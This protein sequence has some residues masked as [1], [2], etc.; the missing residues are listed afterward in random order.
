MEEA[1]LCQC[2]CGEPVKRNFRGTCWNKYIHRHHKTGKFEKGG[3][4][5]NKGVKGAM[6]GSTTSFKK[7]RIPW[8]KGTKGAMK[9][10]NKGTTL[11][12]VGRAKLSEAHKGNIPWNKDKTGIYS[13]EALAK[14]SKAKIGHIPWNKGKTGIY[15]EEH[16]RRMSETRRK[17]K[18]RVFKGS[19]DITSYTWGWNVAFREKIRERDGRICQICGMDEGEN[20][21]RLSVH[22][23]NG[24]RCDSSPCNLI[25]LCNVCHAG[26]IKKPKLWH[27]YLEGQQFLDVYCA[28]H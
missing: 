21:R 27:A 8:N 1:P 4:P 14:M 19:G 7:G 17:G 26:T 3:T 25:S 15:S 6:K 11:D 20:G 28:T 24:V 16:L 5:W 13:E 9:A 12:A 10:W 2:G 22:H 18:S 23:I